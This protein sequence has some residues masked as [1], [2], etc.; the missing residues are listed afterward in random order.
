[1]LGCLRLL[2]QVAICVEVLPT[3]TQLYAALALVPAPLLQPGSHLL[4]RSLTRHDASSA[5]VR[6]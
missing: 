4:V 2:A 3:A 6:S 1:M 5:E